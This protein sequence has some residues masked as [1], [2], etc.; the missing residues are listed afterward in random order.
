MNRFRSKFS[1]SPFQE[2]QTHCLWK[3]SRHILL[4]RQRMLTCCCL[5][6]SRNQKLI[7]QIRFRQLVAEGNR[8]YFNL[9]KGRNLHFN[10]RRTKRE[11]HVR[12]GYPNKYHVKSINFVGSSRCIEKHQTSQMSR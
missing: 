3:V 5:R 4:R 8:N 10:R 7:N 12:Y 1:Y 11:L 9:S 2:N 6:Y